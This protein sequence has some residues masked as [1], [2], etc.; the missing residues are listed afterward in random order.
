MSVRATD[1]ASA[2]CQ[3]RRHAIVS[4]AFLVSSISAIAACGPR[5]TSDAPHALGITS[6]VVVDDARDR[7]IDAEL[8]YPARGRSQTEPHV[9]VYAIEVARDGA[10][11]GERQRPLVVLSHGTGG[12]PFDMAWLARKLVDEGHLVIA[13]AHPGDTFGDHSLLRALETW[14]RPQDVTS[15]LDAV[16]SHPVWRR[17]IDASRV[18]IVGHSAGGY[19]ALA[20]VGATYSIANAEAKCRVAVGD[21]TCELVKP[22][23][24]SSIDYARAGESYADPRISAAVALAPAVGEAANP[25]SAREVTRPVLIFGAKRD[26]LALFDGHAR[27]WASLLP[28]STLVALDDGDHYQFVGPCLPHGRFVSDV[29]RDPENFDRREAQRSMGAHIVRFLV[30]VFAQRA[31]VSAGMPPAPPG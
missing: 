9:F 7:R 24:R 17:R 12:T 30:E 27:H 8:Y 29:C 16:L 6:L 25:K 14:Q 11:A 13:P 28:T 3:R 18:A 19:T 26:Q 23:D 22:I 15:L 10:Y 5:V 31:P 20:S 4:C 1:G 21:P 2:S